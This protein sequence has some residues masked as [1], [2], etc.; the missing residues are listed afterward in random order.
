MD[1]STLLF[2]LKAIA[3][4][5]GIAVI[6]LNVLG[7]LKTETAISLLSV[8]MTALGLAAFL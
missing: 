7:K 8:G 4:A 2:A 6:V 5:M 3:V 1:Q